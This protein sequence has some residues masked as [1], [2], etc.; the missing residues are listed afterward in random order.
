MIDSYTHTYNRKSKNI[1]HIFSTA[2]V[3]TRSE[4]QNLI[5]VVTPQ[6]KRIIN[7]IVLL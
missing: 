4:I 5:S 2:Q 3:L 1:T 6:N 7:Y